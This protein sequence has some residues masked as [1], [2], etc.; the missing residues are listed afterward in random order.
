MTDRELLSIAEQ[1]RTNCYA[2]YSGYSV[3]AAL[4]CADGTVVCGANVENASYGGTI[5]AER[6]AFSAAVSAGKRKFTAIAIVGGKNGKSA[7]SF[8]MP[9]GICRQ[10]MREFCADD[11]R[12]IVGKGNEICVM[13][14]VQLLPGGFSADTME[15]GEPGE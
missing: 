8:F 14:L 10:V 6:S 1:A 2:P 13:T 5:C 12:V 4:L 7:E 11:F 9:C 15:K 3:G